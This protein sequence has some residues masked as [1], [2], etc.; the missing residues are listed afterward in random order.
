MIHYVLQ[1][2]KHEAVEL[3]L[4]PFIAVQHISGLGSHLQIEPL[5][6]SVLSAFSKVIHGKGDEGQEVKVTQQ[7]DLSNVDACLVDALMPFQR[8]GVKYVSFQFIVSYSRRLK[9]CYLD[10][11]IWV[12]YLLSTAA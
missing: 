4:S 7:A 6:R 3:C 5:P 11:R 8:D 9:F 2:D 1:R 10:E 12:G